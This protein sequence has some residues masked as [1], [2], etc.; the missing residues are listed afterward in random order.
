MRNALACFIIMF[1]AFIDAMINLRY[2]WIG[3]ISLIGIAFLLIFAEEF[4]P[5]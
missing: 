3:S 1:V 2:P 4:E 5:K